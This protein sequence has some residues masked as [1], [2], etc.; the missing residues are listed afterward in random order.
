MI[1]QTLDLLFPAFCEMC[2]TELNQGRSICD[3]CLSSLPQITEPLCANCGAPFDGNLPEQIKC[4]NCTDLKYSFEFARAALTGAAQSF[5][6]AHAVKYRRK[7]YLSNDLASPMV[8]TWASDHRFANFRQNTLVVPVPLHWRRQQQRHSNQAFEFARSFAQKTKL[9]LCQ[10]LKRTRATATQTKLNRKQR[11][12][13]LQKAF[14][15]ASRQEKRIKN[16]K[17]ILIDDVF[18]TGATAQACSEI[19]IREGLAQRVAVLTLIRG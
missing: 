4:S 11:L 14:A 2:R 12:K 1:S 9:P 16:S 6:L 5:E 15:I 3:P 10:G 7:F 13:N 17:V 19:L 8:N 18:T